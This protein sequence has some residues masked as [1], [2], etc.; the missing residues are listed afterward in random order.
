MTDRRLADDRGSAVHVL[1]TPIGPLTI[2][3]SDGAVRAVRFARA[4]GTADLPDRGDDAVTAGLDRPGDPVLAVAVAQLREYFAGD[5]RRFDLPLAPDGTEFQRRCWDA[6][7]TLPYG[8][9]ISYR[10]QA[11]RL[12]APTAVRAVGAANG[13]NPIPVIVPCH[14]VIGSDGRLTGFGGG[15]PAKAW[16]LDHER[17]AAGLQ[18]PL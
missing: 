14:R 15:L 1:D 9:T 2:V 10:D 8:E 16:L 12:G 18:L 17:R 7:V 11:A 6:L 5:R 3:V 13:R 4:D